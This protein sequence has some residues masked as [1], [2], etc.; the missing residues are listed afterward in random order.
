II[1]KEIKKSNDQTMN[2]LIPISLVLVVLVLLITFRS[3]SDTILGLIGLGISIVW[4]FGLGQIIGVSFNEMIITTPI[5]IFGLG[6]DYA[7]HVVMRY[8]EEIR[9]GNNV[10][11]AVSLTVTFI[12]V[13]L[14]LAT[15]TTVVGFLSNLTSPVRLIGQFGVLV[16]LGIVSSFVVMTTFVPACRQVLDEWKVKKGKPVLGGITSKSNPGTK[17]GSDTPA[18]NNSVGSKKDKPATGVREKASGIDA[19][20]RTLAYGA[21]GAEHHPHTVILIVLLITGIT[22]YGALNLETEFSQ[23]DFMPSDTDIADALEYLDENFNGSMTDYAIILIKGNITNPEVLRAINDTALNM[24][25]DKGVVAADGRAHTEHILLLIQKYA[26]DTVK[27]GNQTFDS[28]PD[29]AENLSLADTDED[30]IPD[31]NLSYFYDWLYLNDPGAG[32]LIHRDGAGEY[33]GTVLKVY[34]DVKSESE[35][36]DLYSDLKADKG[37]LEKLKNSGILDK[38][39]ISGVPILM[40]T[41]TTSLQTSQMRSIFVTIILSF[42]V[43]TLIFYYTHRSLT[44]G[45]ITTIPVVLVLIWIY[46]IMFFLGMKMNAMTA[47]IGSLTIGLGITYAI[48]ITQRFVEDVGKIEDIDEACRLTVRHTGTA[49]V[50]AGTTTIAA[51]G[52]LMLSNMPPARQFGGIVALTIFLSLVASV[53]ILPTLLVIW[54]KWRKGKGIPHQK[55]PVSKGAE[56]EKQ[57]TET[58]RGDN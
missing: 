19:L 36:G 32:F 47:I 53:F 3:L 20:N 1:N 28:Y 31:R 55:T 27:V 52:T 29:F 33:D 17:D 24:G 21:I 57:T 35:Q 5:L 15:A 8:R 10:K 37:P 13:A 11:E 40:Y 45:L 46:G 7:I 54:A 43:L 4:M 41:T 18:K 34:V 51:F 49:L 14:L 2:E 6:I 48:H 16:A 26:F 23:S 22:G 50:G 12:G 39:V 9:L 44:L 30:G 42:V 58:N 25:N 56:S 38:V